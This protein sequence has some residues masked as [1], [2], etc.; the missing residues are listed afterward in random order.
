[1]G[2]TKHEHNHAKSKKIYIPKTI[3]ATSKRRHCWQIPYQE[4]KVEPGRAWLKGHLLSRTKKKF[5]TTISRNATFL[6]A[7]LAYKG[8]KGGDWTVIHTQ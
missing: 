5:F 2:L 1:M 8:L 3:V 6:K 4:K 7:V